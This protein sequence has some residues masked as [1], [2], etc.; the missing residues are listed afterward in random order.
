MEDALTQAGRSVEEIIGH[1]LK[2]NYNIRK[3]YRDANLN[4]FTI[5][6]AQGRTNNMEEV[7]ATNYQ[8]VIRAAQGKPLLTTYQTLDISQYLV[9]P[10]AYKL[11]KK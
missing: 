4:T 6:D 1:E 3:E 9:A 5:P 11:N 8:N 7:D 10:S 2:H